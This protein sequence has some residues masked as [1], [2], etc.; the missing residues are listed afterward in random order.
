MDVYNTSKHTPLKYINGANT[1]TYFGRVLF[2]EED[3]G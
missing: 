1:I 3:N 2:Q